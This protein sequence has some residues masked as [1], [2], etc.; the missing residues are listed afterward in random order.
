MQQAAK[1]YN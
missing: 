1:Y